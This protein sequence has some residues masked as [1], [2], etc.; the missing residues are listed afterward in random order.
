MQY[1][2]DANFSKEHTAEILKDPRVIKT[3]V[4]Q[5]FQNFIISMF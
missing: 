1:N 5:G 3:V 4:F 2:Q